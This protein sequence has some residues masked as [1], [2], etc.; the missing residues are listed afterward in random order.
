MKRDKGMNCYPKFDLICVMSIADFSSHTDLFNES[1]RRH[2]F[3]YHRFIST[4]NV[5]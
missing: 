2:E 1:I 5:L 4:C 3:S